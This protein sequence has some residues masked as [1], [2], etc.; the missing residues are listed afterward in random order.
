MSEV[1]QFTV[2]YDDDGIRLDRWFTRH[3][4]QIGFATV[5]R[6]AR[7]GQVR[8]DGKRP[9]EIKSSGAHFDDLHR[10]GWDPEARMADQAR[11]GIAAEVIYPS[12]GMI[13]E[14]SLGRNRMRRSM[15]R[16]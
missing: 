7:T 9:E 15:L 10:G 8:I 11:D 5:S 14:V 6:W 16:L 13:I 12:I 2:G 4:P 3:L 1:R